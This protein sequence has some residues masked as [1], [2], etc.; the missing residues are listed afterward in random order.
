MAMHAL[1]GRVGAQERLDARRTDPN[2][3]A[4]ENRAD[5]GD[6]R[7]HDEVEKP[8]RPR[9]R[10]LAPPEDGRKDDS[11]SVEAKLARGGKAHASQVV[12]RRFGGGAVG[13]SVLAAVLLLSSGGAGTANAQV[14]LQQSQPTAGAMHVIAPHPAA[15]RVD[16]GHLLQ[17][18]KAADDLDALDALIDRSPQ[19]AA[20]RNFLGR[21]FQAHALAEL[22]EQKLAS[23]TERHHLD[24]IRDEVQALAFLQMEHY[25]RNGA[26]PIFE[27]FFKP[28]VAQQTEWGGR[29]DEPKTRQ[30]TIHELGPGG[31]VTIDLLCPVSG[32]APDQ[33]PDEMYQRYTEHGTAPQDEH[34]RK[35]ANAKIYSQ[36]NAQWVWLRA[37]GGG[38]DQLLAQDVRANGR[39]VTPVRV[40]LSNLEPGKEYQVRWSP[41][42]GEDPN[43]PIVWPDAFP[44]GRTF[45]VKIAD[46]ATITPAR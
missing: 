30:Y 17:V 42:V 28:G 2:Q 5:E 6:P 39:Y 40:T 20:I 3:A 10:L 38:P 11:S 31:S 41:F 29:W 43:N 23:P 1:E 32:H 25:T 46:D 7:F 26:T 34:L 19:Q 22:L 12:M 44:N 37:P 27:P 4:G 18:L 35:R 24:G 15:R 36:T 13:A 9:G 45:R 16:L 8:A 33:Y 21:T 14:R